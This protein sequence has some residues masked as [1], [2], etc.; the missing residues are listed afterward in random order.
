MTIPKIRFKDSTSN[1][2]KLKLNQ[3]LK[4]YSESNLDAEFNRDDILSLSSIHGIVD[5]KGLLNDTYDKVNHLAY[6]KCRYKDFVYGK[7][8]SAS[9]PFGL[10]KVNN[11]KDGLLSTLYYTFKVA[12]NVSADYLDS[13]FSHLNRTNNFLRGL[14]LVGDRYITAESEFLLSGSI[15]IHSDKNEQQKIAD[16]FTSVD[17]KISLLKKKKEL[18]EQ[19]KKGVT[20]KIFSQELRFKDEEGKDFPEWEAKTLKDVTFKTDK[21]NRNR[22]NLPIYSV[23]NVEGFLPQSEQFEGLDSNEKGYDVSMYKIVGKNTFAYN[24]AR[25]NVGSVGLYKGNSEVIISSLYVCFQTSENLY[26]EF[27]LKFLKSYNFNNQ[28]LR[29]AEGGVRQYLFYENFSQIKIPLP[30]IKE[31]EKIADFLTALDDKIALVE[32]QINKTELWKKGLLQQMF[33]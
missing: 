18:L 23:N 4:R 3:I 16:F 12:D 17:E 27:L 21:K 15:T 30:S 5:R 33:V 7:S 28:V 24:P 10:F 13:Y 29:I 26:D 11:C 31:Q 9:Y 2:I 19:Y 6:K 32:Q 22:L 20:Q 8:I 25:I 14:V 1:F